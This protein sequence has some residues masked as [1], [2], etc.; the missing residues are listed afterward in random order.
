MLGTLSQR[1]A[2]N[3][4]EPRDWP[5]PGQAPWSHCPR[6]PLC[7]HGL[8]AFS[9]AAIMFFDLVAGESR[10]RKACS[11]KGCPKHNSKAL[12]LNTSFVCLGRCAPGRGNQHFCGAA[13]LQRHLAAE[14]PNNS[15]CVASTTLHDREGLAEHFKD[16]EER[17]KLRR[18]LVLPGGIDGSV[19]QG[20][21][22]AAYTWFVRRPKLIGD[23]MAKLLVAVALMI[24]T[25]RGQ[26]GHCQLGG[27]GCQAA[28][29]CRVGGLVGLGERRGVGHRMWKLGKVIPASRQLRRQA[30][31]Q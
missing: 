4:R 21:L 30:G 12:N 26:G 27:G 25:C 13:C 19:A 17:K 24:S 9:F 16:I 23:A 5:G 10:A 2:R 3:S 28:G 18:P 20:R 29:G 11:R 1:G 22:G 7:A 8:A 15:E 14:G 6:A 31:M